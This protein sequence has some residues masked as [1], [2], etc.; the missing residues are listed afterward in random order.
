MPQQKLNSAQ[1]GP[2]FFSSL[3]KQGL[4]LNLMA[5]AIVIGGAALALLIGFFTKTSTAAMVGI[6]TGA[7]T[8]TPSL[9]AALEAHGE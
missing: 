6:F 8:N 4:P 1:V 5:A 7:T 3:R 9:G 2:G